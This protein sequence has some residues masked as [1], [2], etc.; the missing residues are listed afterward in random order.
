MKSYRSMD[1]FEVPTTSPTTPSADKLPLKEFVSPRRSPSV[2]PRS[3]F[4]GTQ[5][6]LPNWKTRTSPRPLLDEGPPTATESDERKVTEVPKSTACGRVKEK[7][8]S[9]SPPSHEKIAKLLCPGSPTAIKFP[10]MVISKAAP[11]LA[12]R[13]L[14]SKGSVSNGAAVYSLGWSPLARKKVKTRPAWNSGAPTTMSK[15]VELTATVDPNASPDAPAPAKV[16]SSSSWI[17]QIFPLG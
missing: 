14:P 2:P 8:L 16:L 15:R 17:T 9:Q 10:S 13:A 3:S 11:N 5:P 4:N 7:T 1:P 12:S 6:P